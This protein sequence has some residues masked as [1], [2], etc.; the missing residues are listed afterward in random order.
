LP[1]PIPCERERRWRP[2]CPDRG[3][4]PGTDRIL[5]PPEK[6]DPRQPQAVAVQDRITSASACGLA[7]RSQP[8]SPAEICFCAL[9]VGVCP[10]PEFSGSGDP[11]PCLFLMQHRT[12]CGHTNKQGAD[13][14]ALV[15]QDIPIAS[16]QDFRNGRCAK[17]DTCSSM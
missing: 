1:S 7:S 16:K 9:T 6:I 10:P 17:D 5:P 15:L 4:R 13:H 14:P 8:Q 2:V 11:L 3:D 12:R